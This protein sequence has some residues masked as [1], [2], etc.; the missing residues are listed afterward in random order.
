MYY[1]FVASFC[2]QLLVLSFVHQTLGQLEWTEGNQLLAEQLFKDGLKQ[3]SS[4]E[5]SVMLLNALGKL[6]SKGGNLKRQAR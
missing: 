5:K 6:H 4:P 3:Q 2:C 1:F